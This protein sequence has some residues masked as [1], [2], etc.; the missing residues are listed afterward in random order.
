MR[1]SKWKRYRDLPIDRKLSIAFAIP[2]CLM[3]VL[4]L[5]I[6]EFAL[7]QYD[8]KIY[9][10]ES[11]RLNS[12]IEN[13][14]GKLNEIDSIS[15]NIAMNPYLQESLNNLS[16]AEVTEYRYG[17]LRAYREIVTSL[18]QSILTE[19]LIFKDNRLSHCSLPKPSGSNPRNSTSSL[20]NQPRNLIALCSDSA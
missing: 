16:E 6:T 17:M 3:P 2:L 18:S 10:Y 19:N 12:I 14:E 4:S 8:H 13:I 9:A 11:D 7:T 20:M 5:S 15:Y 1:Q